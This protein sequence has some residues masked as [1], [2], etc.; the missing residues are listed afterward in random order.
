[1][2]GA[3]TVFPCC[4]DPRPLPPVHRQ[5]PGRPRRTCPMAA[6]P[7]QG[8]PDKTPSMRKRNARSMG[9]SCCPPCPYHLPRPGAAAN[10]P[11]GCQRGGCRQQ[12]SAC[13]PPPPPACPRVAPGAPLAPRAPYTCQWPYTCLPYLLLSVTGSTATWRCPY[14][15]GHVAN[16]SALRQGWHG[17]QRAKIS[18][19]AGQQVAAVVSAH[20]KGHG[21]AGPPRDAR[22]RMQVLQL[23]TNGMLH[24]KV[25]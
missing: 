2:P 16:S 13:H 11:N 12:P 15:T 22:C 18:R 17:Q 24:H 9:T 5:A 7:G 25:S 1:M 6:S 20:A 8:G 23:P 4:P 19:L 14:G 3:R 10:L 21:T